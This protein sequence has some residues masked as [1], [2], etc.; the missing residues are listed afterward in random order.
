MG[1][2]RY[3]QRV[4]GAFI[5]TYAV[6]TFEGAALGAGQIVALNASGYVDPS[7]V[8]SIAGGVVTSLNGL[9]GALIISGGLNVIV[10]SS[11][12]LVLITASGG[13][14]GGGD[15]ATRPCTF[16]P[17]QPAAGQEVMAYTVETSETFPANFASP[18]S[19]GTCKINP[20]S[21]AV[22]TV[23]KNASNVGTISISTGGIFTFA[24]TAG[25][26]ITLNSG[27]RF[28]VVAPGSVDATLSGVSITLVGTR[29]PIPAGVAPPILT[30]RGAYNGSTA[31]NPFDLVSYLGSSYVCIA[32][33]TGNIPT[34]TSFWNLVALA[35]VPGGVQTVNT[36]TGNIVISGGNNVSVTQV[37]QT[38]LIS[39]SGG[40]SVPVAISQG[41]DWPPA[42]PNAMDDEFTAGSLNLA[43]WTWLQQGTATATEANSSL[44]FA[45]PTN[46]GDT[47]RMIYQTLPAAPWTFVAKVSLF[48]SVASNFFQT[49]I[50]LYDS[51]NS[52][53]QTFGPAYDAG[54]HISS[55]VGS[56]TTGLSWA[57]ETVWAFNGLLTGWIYLQLS[58][59]GTTMTFSVS[60]D[61]IVYQTI[62]SAALTSSLTAPSKIGII[63]N[64][65]GSR[66]GNLVCDYFRRTV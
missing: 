62:F 41:V 45:V 17:G 24:T 12:Q 50:G 40:T 51:A 4:N 1:P 15:L 2:N 9:T 42:S 58:L 20:T 36:L 64:N 26:Q 32:V 31:Y 23:F 56:L 35:G 22:Y 28:S 65:N 25:A 16:V 54:W 3:V 60:L 10:N 53:V 57:N 47:P 27:D 11:G 5:E 29:I 66:T 34:N 63:F 8:Y 6:D 55:W 61:G 14:G 13:T 21:T 30:W 59:V 46:T 7:L 52:K 19:Y 43:L 38:V 18:K 37:G 49:G 48:V 33:S 44:N 39:A